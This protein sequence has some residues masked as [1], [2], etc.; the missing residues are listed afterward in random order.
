MLFSALMEEPM[1]VNL[2]QL[3]RFA[4]NRKKDTE[5]GLP[6]LNG[7][8]EPF[9]MYCPLTMAQIHCLATK[10]PRFDYRCKLS[11]GTQP[12]VWIHL[13]QLV[14]IEYSFSIGSITS[15]LKLDKKRGEET[16]F[17]QSHLES[18]SLSFSN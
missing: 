1:E 2:L 14:K 5:N 16:L 4:P 10:W 8:S 7:Q 12:F 6:I 9:G 17:I 15:S 11:A 13:I 18:L 3:D